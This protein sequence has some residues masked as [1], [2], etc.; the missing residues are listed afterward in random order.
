MFQ[1]E[2]P[3]IDL[4]SASE[5]QAGHWVGST[6]LS[7]PQLQFSLNQLP[8]AP[9]CLQLTGS[10]SQLNQASEFLETKGYQVV[11]TIN[12]QALQTLMEKIPGLVHFGQ[13]SQILWK[14]TPLLTEFI[15]Q[16]PTTEMHVL[17]MGCGGGRDAIFLAM[18]GHHVTAIDNKKQVIQRAESFAE[19]YQLQIDWR[20]CDLNH[21]NC[22]PEQS[23]DLIVTVRYLNRTLFDWI[24]KHLKPGG[25]VLFQTFVEGVEKF[26][27]PKNPNF[28]LKKGELAQTF[29]EFE[30]IVDRIELLSDRRP[31]ASFIARR[32]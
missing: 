20:C 15:Q 11:K 24:K 19:N 17:D 10:D 6:H 31:V 32:P 30:K 21:P 12:S 29:S 23:F 28:I 1:P 18:Q 13:E 27:S 25:F 26:D 22:L 5:Y 8:A 2:L 3:I 9:A 14:A 7:W 16:Q 4:R